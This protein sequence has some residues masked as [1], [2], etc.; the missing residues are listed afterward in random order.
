MLNGL[1]EK[2]KNYRKQRFLNFDYTK[3]YAFI[4]VGNH[5][6][7]NLYPVIQFLGIPL[8]YIY[9]RGTN[10]AQKLAAKFENCTGT[11]DLDLILK[12]D[13]VSGVFICANPVAHFTLIKQAFVAGKHVFVEKPPCQNIKEFQELLSLKKELFCTVGLQKRY[14]TISQILRNEVKQ[15]LTY[16]YRYVT[17]S[18]PEGDPILDLFIHPI[19]FVVNVFGSV[20]ETQARRVGNNGGTSVLLMLWHTSGTVG[21]LELS[22]QYSW[23]FPVDELHINTPK[24]IYNACFP[25]FLSKVGKPKEVMNIPLEK[26]FKHNPKEELLYHNT[27]FVPISEFNSLKEQGYHGEVLEFVDLVEGK[28]KSAQFSLEDC[29]G[30]Y[31]L[32]DMI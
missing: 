9:T 8:K 32:A 26:V 15:P 30:F 12:D 28:S 10:N 20:A 5:S 3:K 4:G 24:A 13:E 19:D 14:S 16:N 22:T 27:G 6:L 17:G 7:S 31:E 29:Q 18:Y 25:G 21:Q 1:I 23:S 2:Y 11:N